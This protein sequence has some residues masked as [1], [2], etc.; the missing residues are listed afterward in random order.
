MGREW[1]SL[2][3]KS[4]WIRQ[5]RW[6]AESHNDFRAL[7]RLLPELA[8]GAHYRLDSLENEQ[9]SAM[10]TPSLDDLR[11][12]NSPPTD[13]LLDRALSD[14]RTFPTPFKLVVVNRL[15]TD[16]NSLS[17]YYS[18]YITLSH[19]N[20]KQHYSDRRFRLER[21]LEAG[22]HAKSSGVIPMV[23]RLI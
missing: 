5:L 22:L 21:Q 19:V 17:L 14:D 8:V 15:I 9:S 7:Q 1:S 4:E 2:R 10:P 11:T 3:F 23:D 13:Q 6:S 18:A 16:L 20:Q 12:E